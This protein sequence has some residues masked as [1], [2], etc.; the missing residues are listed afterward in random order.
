MLWLSLAK[1]VA[2]CCGRKCGPSSSQIG[3]DFQAIYAETAVWMYNT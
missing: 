1:S 3:C 2:E